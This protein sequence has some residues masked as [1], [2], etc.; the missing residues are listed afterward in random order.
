MGEWIKKKN[1]T[2][3][4]LQETCFSFKEIYR[5]KVK[6]QN[7]IF[8]V[9][10]NQKRAGVAVLVSHKTEFQSKLVQRDKGG[11]YIVIKGSVQQEDTILCVYLY[12]YTHNYILLLNKI[13]MII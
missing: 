2:V 4:Y 12:I 11:H 10:D 8:H 5:P 9:N 3:G 7:K 1:P 13:C 6:G